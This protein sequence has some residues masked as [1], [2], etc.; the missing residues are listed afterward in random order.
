M[1]N[2]KILVAVLLG[3]FIFSCSNGDDSVTETQ[4]LTEEEAVEIVAASLAK[5]SAGL[6]ETTYEYAKTYEEEVSLNAQCNQQVSDSYNFSHNGSVVQAVYNY[7][8]SFTIN[9]N[10]LNVPQSATFNSSGNGIYTTPRIESD[11]FSAFTATVSGLQPSSSTMTF[12]ATY[13][14]EGTQQLTTNLNTRSVSNDF[15]ATIVDLIVGKSDYEVDSGTGTF[16]LSGSTNQ[17]NFSFDGS[18]LFNGDNTA[19]V[20]INGNQYTINLN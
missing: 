7:N 14:R 12:N 18:I 19:L 13:L 1:K 10:G 8:W 17:G 9:C 11:D 6:N 15:N 4:T 5:E 20:S 2:S 3:S 16:T